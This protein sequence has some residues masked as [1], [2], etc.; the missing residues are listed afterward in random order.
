MGSSDDKDTVFFCNVKLLGNNCKQSRTAAASVTV[1][2]AGSVASAWRT[3]V[4]LLHGGL[5]IRW[6]MAGRRESRTDCVL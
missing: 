5:G 3:P 1:A 2:Y 4:S 6:Y